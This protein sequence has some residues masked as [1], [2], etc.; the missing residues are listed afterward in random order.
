M[1]LRS[2][3]T[4]VLSWLSCPHACNLHLSLGTRQGQ[5]GHSYKTFLRVQVKTT[6]HCSLVKK[7]H[8]MILRNNLNSV[9]CI[10]KSEDFCRSAQ[11]QEMDWPGR[12]GTGSGMEQVKLNTNKWGANV[13]SEIEKRGV[14][15][16][17]GRSVMC[18]RMGPGSGVINRY[19]MQGARTLWC[20]FETCCLEKVLSS[21]GNITVL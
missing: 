7:P 4:A 11:Y 3:T 2:C 1:P 16:N 18:V 15:Y 12:A 19:R 14:R 10:Y 5:C 20:P 6:T 8:T 21:S 13:C 9:K 17:A